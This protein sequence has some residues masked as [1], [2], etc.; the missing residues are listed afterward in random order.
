METTVITHVAVDGLKML[1]NAP[2][3]IKDKPST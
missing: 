3:D 2:I 1:V